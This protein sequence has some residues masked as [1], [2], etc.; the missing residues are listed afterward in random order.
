MAIL[1]A[2][3]NPNRI[4]GRP[5]RYLHDGGFKGGIY[6]VNPNR[7]TVQGLKAY[8]SITDVPEAADV[9]LLA[10]PAAA[11]EDAIS[12]CAKKGVGAA[13][14]FSAGYAELGADGAAIQDRIYETASRAGMRILGPNCLG[15]FNSALGFYGT[16]TQSLDRG[17]PESG[18][19]AVISQSGAYGSHLAYLANKRGMG[20]KYMITTGNEADVEMAEVLRYLADDPDVS[21]IMAYA[22]GVRE[23][24]RFRA[25]LAK[26]HAAKKPI[27][28]MKVG[29]S[30][31]G[32]RAAVSHTA[33]L[34]GSDAI[35]EALFREFGVHRAQ[36]TDEQLDVA[37]AC[38]RGVYPAGGK[39]GIV[40]LS[41]GIGVQM[42][43]AAERFGLDVSPMPAAAQ[44]KLKDLLPY[45][46][47]E[48]PVDTTAQALNDM[49][50]LAKNFEVMLEEGGYHA[51]LGF[52][53]G[54]PATRTLA[55][56]LKEAILRGTERFRDRLMV[57]EMVADRDTIKSYEDAGFLSY[58]D[59]DRAIASIAALKNIREAH[60][61]PLSAPPPIVKAEALPSG[62]LSE[63]AA[64]QLLREA[65]VPVLDERLVQ[66]AD[67]AVSAAGDVGLPVVMK[68]V[69]PDIQHK[70]VIGGVIVGVETETAVREAH[71]LL[72][73]RAR[74]SAPKA[75]VDGV[76]V[77]PMAPK[78]I[79]AIVGVQNDPLFGPMVM[80]GLGGVFV[81]VFKDVTFRMAPFDRDE[82]LRMTAE[83]KGRALFDGVRGAARADI[84]ALADLLVA[85][86]DFA[87]THAET[88]ESI[89]L[90]PVVVF[91]KGRG[92]V[93]LDALIESRAPTPN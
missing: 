54:V 85:V 81:E 78:G 80:F 6:P 36:T 69:S 64:K 52:F 1:G 61:R 19:I 34:A 88:I 26:A 41:G 83:I 84:G 15:V 11:T 10:I 20:V 13:I 51:I 50:L 27:V 63:H 48:N 47:V 18:S 32:A 68:I 30:D 28:F 7:E 67:T 24:D 91:E 93:A 77:A 75:H 62:R 8:A 44:K 22:E 56:P 25:A 23:P 9:A 90:N 14:I 57:L 46:A 92:V 71:D 3:D 72:R 38:A 12:A 74:A 87:A 65:G 17:V 59:G 86:G 76:L 53:G 31:V 42:C 33:S 73:E 43:D 2:S 49:S 82:A 37:Y 39:L 58:E 4:G 35:Y 21:V 70:T 5:L 89:D 55:D 79:E 66:D 45:A 16:F 29:R 60:E 40:T